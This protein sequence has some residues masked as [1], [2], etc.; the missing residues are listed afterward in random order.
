MKKQFKRQE[1]EFQQPHHAV[2]PP[3]FSEKTGGKPAAAFAAL[4][5]FF[6]NSFA[7]N[8]SKH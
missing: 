8:V 5:I 1:H 6:V 4:A 2:N 7:F 3:E